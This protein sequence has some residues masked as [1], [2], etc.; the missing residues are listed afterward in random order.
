MK[1]LQERI[2]L[3]AWTLDTT[4][5]ADVLRIAREAGYAAVELRYADYERALAA[6]MTREQ[7]L[8]MIRSSGMKVGVMGVEN[9]LIFSEGNE[10]E[11][12]LASFEVS[13]TNAVAVG[14]DTLMITAGRNKP[15]SVKDAAANCRKGG[16]LAREHGLRLALEFSAAHPLLNRLEVAREIVALAGLPNCGLLLDTYHL[17]RSG[18]VGSGFKDVPA[19]EIFAFQFSDVPQ[20][21]PPEGPTAL[22]RLPPGKGD[23]H[24]REVFGLL[25]EKDYGG[26]INYEAPNPAQW[27]RPAAEV[28]REGIAATREFIAQ[29]ASGK[30]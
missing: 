15:T 24:W 21:P 9:G 1:G 4:P 19:H 14:C 23:V 11:K 7:Y 25:I 28:A 6:G 22:D 17:H 27:N 29:A 10:R 26:Y 20:D 2:G 18:A 30:R 3:H 16:L 5:L 13:C 12:L 8:D